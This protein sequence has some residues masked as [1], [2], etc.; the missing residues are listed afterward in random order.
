M[1]RVFWWLAVPVLAWGETPELHLTVLRPP[2]VEAVE[3]ANT[4]E[5]PALHLTVL[6]PR[7]SPAKKLKDFKPYTFTYAVGL[8]YRRDELDWHSRL[9]PVA[10]TRERW[11]DLDSLRLAGDMHLTT[12][13]R[14]TF[15][16]GLAYTWVLA[17]QMNRS[18]KVSSGQDSFRIAGDAGNGHVFEVGGGFGYRFAPSWSIRPYLEP[19]VGYAYRKQNLHA[20]DFPDFAGHYR[21]RAEWYG[22]WLGLRLGMEGQ[23]W[24]VFGQ[25][26][27]HFATYR[28]DGDWKG[29]DREI[30][31][32]ADGFGVVVRAGGS[33]R[34]LEQ[35]ALRLSFDFE[36]WQTDSGQDRTVFADG[37]A[38][39]TRLEDTNWRSLGGNL[40]LEYQ[41]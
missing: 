36:R 31:Q 4:E 11:Q 39:K 32:Q 26:E 21:Y 16:G 27:Y 5:S 15:Q 8:G 6:R 35:L 22:P 2:P 14:L 33:Y 7:A 9:G 24:G 28:A 17:G 20:E 1:R 34:I 29:Q 3:V 38:V 19:L 25:G 12:P 18:D 23:K 40:A 41:F 13:I 37:V 10:R 30:R